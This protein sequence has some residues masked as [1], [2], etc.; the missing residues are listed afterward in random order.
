HFVLEAK[1]KEAGRSDE[2]MLRKAYGQARSY[3]THLPGTTPPYLILLDVAKTMMVWDRWEGGFGGFVLRFNGH[4]FKDAEGLPLTP[5]DLAV[6]LEAAEA[7]WSDVEPAI[8][9]TLL[10]RA[11]NPKERHRLG[12]EYTWR[13]SRS[14]AR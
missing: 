1:D 12:A 14:L 5:D 9:G 10:T 7:D 8:F 3:I 13:R 6:L 11:L 2:L 4:F